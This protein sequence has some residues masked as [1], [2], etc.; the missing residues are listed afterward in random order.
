MGGGTL[1][2]PVLT[3][4]LGVPQLGAQALNLVSFIPMSLLALTI[5]LKN[6]LVK[7][8]P[9][10]YIA[11]PAVGASIAASFLAASAP[12]ELLRRAFGFFLIALG[13]VSLLFTALNRK[14]G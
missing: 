9:V 4:G 11:L 7:W 2:V 12:P 5:H 1:L 6:K 13:G 10:L 3:L 8:K 14:S